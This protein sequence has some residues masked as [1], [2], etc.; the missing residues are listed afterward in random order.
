MIMKKIRKMI[1]LVIAMVMVLSM[2]S[3][4][5][6]APA[7]VEAGT[8]DETLT[9][10][11]LKAG[12]KV[13]FYKVIEWV[14]DAEDNVKGWKATSD[15]A[16][17]LTEEKLTEMLLGNPNATPAVAPIGVNSDI[18]GDLARLATNET[19]VY[20]V[21]ATGTSVTLNAGA[22]NCGPGMYMALIDPVN[23]NDVYN[24]VFVSSDFNTDVAGSVSITDSYTSPDATV[25]SSNTSLDKTA[26]ASEDA[27][28][29]TDSAWRTTAIGDEV[30]FTVVT[31]IPVYGDVYNSPYFAVHDKL[32]DLD[33]DLDSVTVTEPADLEKSETGDYNVKSAFDGKGYTLEFSPDYL[34][35]VTS[36]PRKVTIQYKAK[37]STTAPLN[38]NTE[39]NEVSTEFSHI[40]SSESDHAFKK[41]T[42]QHYTFTLDAEGLGEQEEAKG[43]KTSEIIKVGVDSAGNPIT[44]ETATGSYI[45]ETNKYTNPLAGAEFKL[46]TDSEC[47]N[48]YKAKNAA[49]ELQ[50]PVTFV[51]GADGRM[52]ITG[53]D[54]GDYY[55]QETKA[56]A[57][58]VKDSAIHHIE[59]R[60][61][62]DKDVEITEWT[63]DGKTWISDADYTALEDKTGYK[64]YTYKTDI[65]NGYTVKIDGEDT[66]KYKFVNNSTTDAEIDWT[67]EPPVEIPFDIVNTKGVELPSTG[68]IGTTMFYIVGAV[69][70]IGAGILLVTRRRMSAR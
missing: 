7:E 31:Y 2:A 1:A 4:T 33:L 60:A 51:T 5:M 12:D 54:A 30:T 65:I 10:S 29:A 13:T 46:Y 62:F 6:A 38:I 20:E 63:L 43:K 19:K 11:G 52:T 21:T 27:W 28:D 61:T 42:T 45:T 35:D 14:N 3:L 8:Y 64:S 59:I 49:G 15:Y 23:V 41:D 32:T 25:K 56:P 9:V 69:L 18:A 57:G 37:V 22:E 67:I 16:S 40:P 44:S 47:K 26:V 50:D 34:K 55:F 66:A 48:E 70:V 17:V 58:F 24:P 53:L 36:A 39:K 68:G